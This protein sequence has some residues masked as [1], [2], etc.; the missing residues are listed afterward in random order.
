MTARAVLVVGAGAIGQVYG[1]FLAQGGARVT[2]YV[3]ERYREHTARGLPLARL[4]SRR[5]RR[6]LPVIS[7]QVVSSPAEVSQQRYD[8]VYLTIPS[9]ALV[10]PWLE[11]L[12]AATG[13]AIIIGL[14]PGA[15]DREKLIAAGATPERLVSG[16]L[17]LVAYQAP[18]PGE[19]SQVPACTTVWF[20]PGAPCLFSGPARARDEVLAALT[21]GGLPARAH[22]DVPTL[23]AFGSSATVAF[24][25]ALEA[26]GW[27]LAG[28]RQPARLR[29]ACAA[30][31]E[32]VSLAAR[33]FGKPPLGVRLASR[34]WVL[35]AA[36]AL[37]PRLAP[38]PLETYLRVHFTKVGEQTRHLVR[39]ALERG[40]A[41]GAEAPALSALL[42]SA[43]PVHFAETITSSK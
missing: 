10:R 2:Y 39:A 14:T 5:R 37:A 12:L 21:A 41:A 26:A 23:G 31:R 38:F 11:E 25:L 17:S 33:D 4:E 29:Q 16:F 34:A 35:R 22:R 8:Q 40:R 30:M 1:H 3:R 13:E 18:L 15:G 32:I 7:P 20:P 24:M 19:D 6:A 28:L 43:Q 9:D 36:L 42:E 27:S